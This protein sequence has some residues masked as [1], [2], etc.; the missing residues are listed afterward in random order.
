MR[1]QLFGIEM[2]QFAGDR[3]LVPPRRRRQL[4]HVQPRP[5][6]AADDPSH[7]RP[8]HADRRRDLATRPALPPQHFDPQDDGR[9][10]RVR[11]AMRP[12]AA[13]G[14]RL[15]RP[16]RLTHFRTVFSATR[17]SRP[18]RRADRPT[19]R[20]WRTTSAR[21]RGVNRAFL[22]MFI[23]GSSSS[24]WRVWRPPPSMR[25]PGWTTPLQTTS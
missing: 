11:A 14:A 13:V 7:G 22:W 3:A 17:A 6:T 12:R 23:R 8:A 4:Q 19:S 16:R 1:P 5:A 15:P 18:T 9:R 24:I 20:T 21:P 10:C 2:H 25:L